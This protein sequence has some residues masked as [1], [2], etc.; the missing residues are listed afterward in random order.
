MLIALQK[1]AADNS[2]S[3]GGGGATRRQ[4]LSFTPCSC[5]VCTAASREFLDR[6]FAAAM[7]EGMADYEQ[8]IAPVKRQLFAELL[9]GLHDWQVTPTT[10]QPAHLLELGVG[11]GPNLRFYS[12]YYSSAGRGSSSGGS[13]GTNGSLPPLHITGVDPNPF[14]RPYLEENMQEAGWPAECFTWVEG[15]A[16]ALPAASASVDALVC[17]LVG[18]AGSPVI[19]ASATPASCLLACPASTLDPSLGLP[20]SPRASTSSCR[21]CARWRMW[22]RCCWRRRAC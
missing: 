14:M 6:A 8:S 10:G 13:G 19:T 5:V 4:L 2:S 21:C 9:G 1:G 15:Q 12:E 3:G 7:A 20:L 22:G 18:A 17:T 16:E 11:T